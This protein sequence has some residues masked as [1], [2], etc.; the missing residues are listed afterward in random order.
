MALPWAYLWALG[1][2]DWLALPWAYLWALG[3]EDCTGSIV[4]GKWADL[5]CIDLGTLNSQPVYDPLS[6]VVYTV[7]PNQVKDVWVA[8]RHQV[9]DGRLT[10]IDQNEILRRTSEWQQR[11]AGTGD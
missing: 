10:Q 7:L 5:A 11:I 2:E 4:P 8:G 9:E 6:Q 1:L 3:L